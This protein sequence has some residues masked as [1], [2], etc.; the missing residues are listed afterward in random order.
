MRL[1]LHVL[2]ILLQVSVSNF[3]VLL[4]HRSSTYKY[5][6]FRI[7]SGWELSSW[8]V[9]C[10]QLGR[11]LCLIKLD[12]VHC[13]LISIG[14]GFG[15][16]QIFS[17]I[18]ESDTYL[19]SFF[20]QVHQFVTRRLEQFLVRTVFYKW[21][22]FTNCAF[23]LKLEFAFSFFLCTMRRTG[24]QQGHVT[25]LVIPV[26]A[27]IRLTISLGT[28][29]F[30]FAVSW[31]QVDKGISSEVVR[32]I[33]TERANWPCLAAKSSYKVSNSSFYYLVG[34]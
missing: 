26:N 10:F 14:L 19:L 4:Y 2:L 3:M 17:N 5:I 12:V 30:T 23:S 8:V 28:Y 33:L 6:T 27:H 20:C 11:N 15:D 29:M 31:L 21:I 16:Q 7:P 22:A 9:T 13:M 1:H 24:D 18:L 34:T 32:S 25:K